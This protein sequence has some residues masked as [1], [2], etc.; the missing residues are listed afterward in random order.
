MI[1]ARMTFQGK[2]AEAIGQAIQPDNL[3]EMLMKAEGHDLNFEFKAQKIGTLLA[4]LDDLLMNLKI[5]EDTM[6]CAEEK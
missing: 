2:H 4:T 3:P 1:R 5:A 6:I